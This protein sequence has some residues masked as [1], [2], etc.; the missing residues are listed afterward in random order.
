MK[1]IKLEILNLASLDNPEGE[2]INFEEGALGDASIFSIVGPTGSGK[3]TLLDA[4]CLA[5]YNRAPRYPLLKGQ[6][7]QKINI[8][9]GEDDDEKNRL[10]P[11]D[12]RNILTRGKKKGYA[13]L[14]FRANDGSFYRAEWHVEF[15]RVQYANAVTT[16]YRIT[17]AGS[18]YTE[19]ACDWDSLPQI[20]GLDYEQFLRTVLIAQGSF[21]NFLTAKEEERYQLLEKLIGCEGMY[22]AISSEIRTKEKEA[23]EALRDIN[24]QVEAFRQYVL[25]D[26][27]LEALNR[28]IATLKEA[29]ESQAKQLKAIENSLDW[30]T[31]EGN[32]AKEIMTQT[33]AEATARQALDDIK[34]ALNRLSLH[35]ALLT[36]IDILREVKRLD[37]AIAGATEAIAGLNDLIA[38]Q[39]K[40]IADGQAEKTVLDTTAKATQEAID[41]T[42]PHIIKARDLRA[43]IEP[44]TKA[45]QEKEKALGAA[46]Q[47]SEAAAKAVAD[48]AKA[49]EQTQKE[50]AKAAEALEALKAE[51]EQQKRRLLEAETKAADNL[52]AAL[53]KVEGLSADA[54]LTAKDKAVDDLNDLTA[55]IDIVGRISNHEEILNQSSRRIDTLSKDNADIEAERQRL[56]IDALKQE[57]DV[58]QRTYTLM[59]SEDWATHRADLHDEQPCPLCGST[60]HPYADDVARFDAAASDFLRLL[61]TKKDAL[62]AQQQAEKDLVSRLSKNQGELK[63][64]EATIAAARKDLSREEQRWTALA[65]RHASWHKD[66]AA[67][68]GMKPAFDKARTDSQEA[69]DAYNA[70]QKEIRSLQGLKDKASKDKADYDQLSA[71]RQK[72]AEDQVIKA[73]KALEGHKAQTANLC[74][75]QTVSAETLAIATGAKIDAEA[76]LKNLSEKF[77]AELQG[78]D[79]DKV[80]TQLNEA[81]RAADQAVTDKAQAIADLHA[82]LGEL[83]GILKAQTAGKQTDEASRL[84]KK[85]ELDRWIADYNSNPACDTIVDI[86]VVAHLLAANDN[87]E[88]IRRDKMAKD[89]ALTSAQTLRRKAETDLAQ[90]QL[91]RPDKSVEE[92][93]AA[94]DEL[95]QSTTEQAL[96]AACIKLEQ[97]TDALKNM[98]TKAEEF[99]QA[100]LV[101]DDWHAISASIGGEKGSELRKIAQCYTLRFLVEHANAEIRKFNSRYELMQVKNSLGIRVIDHDRADDV[102]DTT[103]LSGGE[104]FIVSL[105]LALG[106]SALSSRNISFDNLFIDEGFGTLDPDTLA[107]VIDSL[108]MLQTAQGKKVGV[109]SHTDTMSERITT[110]IRVIPNAATGSSRIELHP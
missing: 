39:N 84:A 71:E 85:A 70:A 29:A 49:I 80:E 45:L 82:K 73:D 104:T 27:D 98:G 51:I 91:S 86:D 102:R 55:A 3:S 79:P 6:K 48:N 74:Q 65:A 105:G 28:D 90:H 75:Q 99:K 53:K 43:Q 95:E 20:I 64:L 108:A 68:E 36:P 46:R 19:E 13:K 2:V 11:S 9:G 42:F 41:Q 52:A 5:L 92:L 100:K 96:T 103:S 1:L 97:H 26:D 67:L 7:K 57:V 59:T 61:K 18:K 62:D 14:T 93:K 81:K 25:A 106:L 54:L 21:A 87:W 34:E 32:L 83:Q 31:T 35:D 76:Q 107:T 69:L 37:E 72:G 38:K 22:T 8:F 23:T 89:S 110:Q 12:S 88:D 63:Q 40:A 50:Q 58:M 17:Q 10:A 109:I 60:H 66:K 24:A 44:A 78:R 16:L 77:R 47:A 4:I 56:Q 33:E 30:Y 101:F 94:K 15:K